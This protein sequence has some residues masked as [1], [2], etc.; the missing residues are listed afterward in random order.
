MECVLLCEGRHAVC[1]WLV[2]QVWIACFSFI[3]KCKLSKRKVS[4]TNLPKSVCLC[5]LR[6]NLFVWVVLAWKHKMPLKLQSHIC[7]DIKVPFM[8]TVLSPLGPCPCSTRVQGCRHCTSSPQR[9][10]GRE[11]R[12]RSQRQ[13][14]SS[15]PPWRQTGRRWGEA[16]PTQ[17]SPSGSSGPGRRQTQC[18]R[19]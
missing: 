9:S 6:I 7:Y 18:R 11:R 16:G 8:H 4:A 10:R 5:N 17:C 3:T 13:R 1:T 19:L 2:Q 14:G 15:E 12:P